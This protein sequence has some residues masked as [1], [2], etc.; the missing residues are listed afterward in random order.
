[1]ACIFIPKLI[2][3]HDEN[4]LIK[5]FDQI[6]E[7]RMVNFILIHSKFQVNHYLI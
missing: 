7:H 2:N 6:G 4:E 5:K 1:M 3:C